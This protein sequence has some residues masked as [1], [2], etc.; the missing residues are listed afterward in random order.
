MAG[1]DGALHEKLDRDEQIA[2]SSD[3]RFGY[4][5]TAACLL[6]GVVSFWRHGQF[7]YYWL[8]ASGVFAL[9]AAIAPGIL[10]PLNK[11][12]LKLAVALSKVTTPIVMGLLFFGFI[13]P[14]A[15]FVRRKD[16]LRLK[17]DP[18]ARSYWIPR[19]PPGPAPESLKHQ[20]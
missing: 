4:T 9:V 1:H 13:T 17:R 18:A 10:A 19:D 5:F 3:R 12:W 6:I 14:M 11:A 7:A 16:P 2:G 15:Q 20:F 8:A